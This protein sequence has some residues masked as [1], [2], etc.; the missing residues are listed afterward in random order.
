MNKF[1]NN[2]MRAGEQGLKVL[3]DAWKEMKINLKNK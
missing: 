2:A 1:K 3:A